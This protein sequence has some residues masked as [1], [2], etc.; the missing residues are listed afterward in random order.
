MVVLITNVTLRFNTSYFRYCTSNFRKMTF[1]ALNMALTGAF[2]IG[3]PF[4]KNFGLL[5]TLRFLQV[6]NGEEAFEEVFPLA[7][8]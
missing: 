2:M 5:V 1:M 7:K 6:R 4:V 8:F 3:L